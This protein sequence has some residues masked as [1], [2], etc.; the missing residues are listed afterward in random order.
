MTTNRLIVLGLGLALAAMGSGC[1]DL[2]ARP[3]LGGATAIPALE[4]TPDAGT[5]PV[6][7]G[8]ALTRV[9][10][11][12]WAPMTY[13]APFD[14]VAHP[15]I[16]RSH[17]S[18]TTDQQR[19]VGVAPTRA[20]AL[21]LPGDPGLVVIPETLWAHAV[22]LADIAL[23]PVRAIVR[24]ATDQAVS[25][26]ILYKRTRPGAWHAGVLPAGEGAGAIRLPDET[27]NA[28]GE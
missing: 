3:V 6:F 7:P 23:L 27:R 19:A 20:T 25:P 21:D 11:A 12:D 10:R 1:A 28:G 13:L 17:I 14:G 26:Q 2:N 16:W 18:H 24:P 5:L 8:P 22:A 4:R 9:D 15:P